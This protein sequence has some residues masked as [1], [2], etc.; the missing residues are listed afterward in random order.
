MVSA[1]GH[2]EDFIF[3]WGRRSERM[4]EMWKY[5]DVKILKSGWLII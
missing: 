5:E 2:R 3:N 4:W 1:A